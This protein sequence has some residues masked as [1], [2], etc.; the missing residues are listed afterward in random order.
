MKPTLF[1]FSGLPGTGKTTLS[2]KYAALYKLPYFRLDT[3]EHGLREVCS[4]NVQ[5][6]G[7]RL[8]YRIVEENLLLGNNV[9]VDCCNPIQLTRNEWQEIAVKANSDY[10]NIEITCTDKR[11]HRERSEYR[12]NDIKG[13][14]LPSWNEIERREYHEWNEER[15]RIDTSNNTEEVSFKELITKVKDK[16]KDL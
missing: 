9:V 3:I 10:L 6:E 15:I 16:K 2:K 5:G 13:F 12:K 1:I 11:V 14:E 8:A 4:I 7:Y